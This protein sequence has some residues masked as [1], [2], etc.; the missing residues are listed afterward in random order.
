MFAEANRLRLNL[1]NAKDPDVRKFKALAGA[2][3]VLARSTGA[4]S[5]VS[6]SERLFLLQFVPNFGDT[7][8]GATAVLDQ[9]DKIFEGI[10]TGPG[11]PK[12]PLP[13]ENKDF[14]SRFKELTE[15]GKS[16]EEAFSIMRGEGY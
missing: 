8:E 14:K 7:F 12:L 6:D 11:V 10:A 1:A 16:K 13:Q 3:T 5:R 4:D 9:A 15:S 2:I